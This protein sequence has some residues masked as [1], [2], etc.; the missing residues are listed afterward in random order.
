MRPLWRWTIGDVSDVGWEILAESIWQ[1]RKVYSEFD[2]VI[3][4]NN[5]DEHKIQ[6]LLKFGIPLFDQD[7][8]VT[9]YVY[10]DQYKYGTDYSWKLVPP[11][12]RADS[13]ELWVDNDLVIRDRIPA[14]DDWLHSDSAIISA[15]RDGIP[16]YGR[17]TEL[18]DRSISCCAGFFGL[19][20]NFN[21]EGKISELCDSPLVEY[22][23][24]GLVTKIVTDSPGWIEVPFG[25]LLMLGFWNTD[26]M[27][28]RSCLPEGIH[29]VGSNRAKGEW[30]PWLCYKLKT[31]PWSRN[32]MR[33]L[34]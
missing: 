24:Q 5:L 25:D 31:Q 14:L 19:P 30:K 10:E 17:Y 18:I 15:S 23:E 34:P 6:R 33:T 28:F 1:A 22:D 4:H 20:P 9:S 12:L 7:K 32:R 3:C 29:F 16:R 21:F 8:A 27:R 11:R 26:R 13:H 2:F